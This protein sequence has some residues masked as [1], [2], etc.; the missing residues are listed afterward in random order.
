MPKGIDNA[1]SDR[2]QVKKTAQPPIGGCVRYIYAKALF[3][4]VL[5]G[6]CLYSVN[7]TKKRIFKGV[8]NL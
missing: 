6:L 5:L 7:C 2:S 4:L 8:T 1:R 3:V